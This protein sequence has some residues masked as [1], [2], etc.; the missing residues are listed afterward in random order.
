M[1]SVSFPAASLVKGGRH[2]S[3]ARIY[4]GQKGNYKVVA[5]VSESPPPYSLAKPLAKTRIDW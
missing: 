2:Y 3:H 5:F 1:D 4:A